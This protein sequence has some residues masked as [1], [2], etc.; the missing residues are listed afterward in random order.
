MI[1]GPVAPTASACLADRPL[2][3]DAVRLTAGGMLGAWQHRNRTATLRHCIRQ[4]E[5]GGALPNMRRASGECDDPFTGFHFSD[6]DIYKVLEAIGW[7]A[8]RSDIAEFGPFVD[9]T[10]ALLRR[11]QRED[12][13]LNSFFQTVEPDRVFADFRWGH[14]LYCLGHLLQAGIA[15]AR[16]LGRRDLL[17]IG[18]RFVDLVDERFGPGGE[19]VVCGH[20]EIET[21]LV[22]LHRLTGDGRHLALAQEFIDRRGHRS[23]GEDRFGYHYFQDHEPVRQVTDATG[24]AVR[25]LYLA[26][27]AADVACEIGEAEVARATERIWSSAFREKQYITGGLGSRHRDEAFGDPFELPPDRAYA[28][29]C[30]SIAGFHLSW[31][32]LLA[33]GRSTYADEMERALVNAIAESTSLDGEHFFYSNPLQLRTRRDGEHEQAPSRRVGWYDCACCPPNLA[34]LVSS[35]QHYIASTAADEAGRL[36]LHLLADA[37]IDLA[38]AGVGTGL[39][40]IRTEYPWQAGAVLDFDEPFGGVVEVRMPGWADEAMIL[41]DGSPAAPRRSPEGYLVVDGRDA[42]VRSIVL[43]AAMPVRV[44][45]PH[46]HLDASR[47]TVAVTRGPVVYCLEQADLPAGVELEDVIVDPDAVPCVADPIVDLDGWRAPSLRAR[48]RVRRRA[49]EPYPVRAAS[50]PAGE[51]FDTVLVPYALWGNRE[52]GAMRVWLPVL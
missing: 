31:R 17:E 10:V 23:V 36:R 39:L 7:E 44:R 28:E 15:W 13:Y 29:T 25:Q 43:D 9:D 4:L 26:A 40:R 2:P 12:G 20:P 21:A 22:E 16:T 47:G 41:I 18:L 19:R 11:A 38:R 51:S 1:N 50:T 3:L 24:H 33:T 8:A 49:G 37:E 52:P 32:L 27:G 48:G 6:S 35:L 45:D 30:A 34:R 42:P 14:E 46:P 5:S